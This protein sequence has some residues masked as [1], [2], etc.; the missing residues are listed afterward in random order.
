VD[1]DEDMK[2]NKQ[3][4]D[5]DEIFFENKQSTASVAAMKNK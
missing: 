5:G 1:D 3:T 2:R 4:N